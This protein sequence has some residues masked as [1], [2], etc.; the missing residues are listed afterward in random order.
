VKVFLGVVVVAA[1]VWLLGA[2]V[3]G[4]LF[5]TAMT[6]RRIW[7]FTW[8]FEKFAFGM[9]VGFVLGAVVTWFAFQKRNAPA[10][11]TAGGGPSH[12]P[13]DRADEE[14]AALRRELSASD[15]DR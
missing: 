9:V 15:T 13:A 1:A 4:I 14:L 5:E 2:A 12:S 8:W 7:L 6:T 10:R 11:S 3:Q